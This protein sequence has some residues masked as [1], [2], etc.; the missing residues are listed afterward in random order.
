MPVTLS[1]WLIICFFPTSRDANFNLASLDM[2]QRVFIAHSH[3][4]F[5]DSHIS[6]SGAVFPTGNVEEETFRFSG[7]S[8]E[9]GA[10]G[11]STRGPCLRFKPK[12]FLMLGQCLLRTLITFHG[13][14]FEMKTITLCLFA[15]QTHKLLA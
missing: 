10:T 4:S 6:Q 2:Q 1:D 8:E 3:H 5:T 7:L 15:Y 11:R 12:T 9:T 14:A 13:R